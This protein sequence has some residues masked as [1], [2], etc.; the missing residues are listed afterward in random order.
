MIAKMGREGLTGAGCVREPATFAL[1][2]FGH[3]Y[4]FAYYYYYF[5]YPKAS[6]GLLHD[7]RTAPDGG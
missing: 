7:R 5:A 4:S 2:S 6:G 3:E 1:S